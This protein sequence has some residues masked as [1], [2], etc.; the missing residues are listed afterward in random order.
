TILR[1]RLN[2]TQSLH[3]ERNARTAERG[4]LSPAAEEAVCI[5]EDLLTDEWIRVGAHH[6]RSGVAAGRPTD[7]IARRGVPVHRRA[8]GVLRE[9]GGLPAVLRPGI[10]GRGEERSKAQ[11]RSKQSNREGRRIDS[12]KRHEAL[13]RFSSPPPGKYAALPD[14]SQL[15]FITSACRQ[16]RFTSA[17]SRRDS[18]PLLARSQ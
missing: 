1:P 17:A 7:H 2:W 6:D 3:F 13:P 15:T 16:L 18:S 14:T 10:G 11:N 5:A 9:G 4:V 12:R 8:V